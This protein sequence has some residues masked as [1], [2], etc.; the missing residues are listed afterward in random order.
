MRLF[1]KGF[2]NS[3]KTTGRSESILLGC[4]KQPSLS[5]NSAIV[6]MVS[7]EDRKMIENINKMIIVRG[8]KTKSG[9]KKRFRMTG[10]GALKYRAA[11]RSHGMRRHS[12]KRNLQKGKLKLLTPGKNGNLHKRIKQ[13]ISGGKL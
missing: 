13:L 1:S 7:D 6:S 5:W 4:I 9:V 10:S 12:R 2:S 3:I 11:G 8:I